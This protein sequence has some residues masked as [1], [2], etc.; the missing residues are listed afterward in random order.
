[1]T[2]EELKAQHPAIYKAAFDEGKTAGL[3]EGRK[4]GLD[5]GKLAGVVEGQRKE[6]DRIA[7]IEKIAIPGAEAIVAECKK[8][9]AITAEQAA[10]R[11]LADQQT[12]HAAIAADVA[13]AGAGVAAV[14]DALK[15]PAALG[16]K[17]DQ[18][19]DAALAEVKAK[20]EAKK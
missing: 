15:P 6:N 19:V 7:A 10:M 14:V 13:K 1:M 2:L 9:V 4:A 11:I 16:V 5:E 3:A 12:R 8:D 18:E 17:G 20:R